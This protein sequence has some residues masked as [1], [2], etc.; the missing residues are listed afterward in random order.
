MENK[1]EE[2]VE[3]RRFKESD[4]NGV[5]E[6]IMKSLENNFLT[7]VYESIKFQIWRDVYTPEYIL[8]MSKRRHLYVAI[9]KGKVVGSAAVSLENSVAYISCV[10]TNSDYQGLGIGRKLMTAV[11]KDE[12]SVKAGK[13]YLHAI[14]TASPFYKKVGFHYET[15]YPEVIVDCGIEVIPMVKEL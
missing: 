6:T 14:M 12:I 15:E 7:R 5:H 13:M 10:Y 8:G 3:I 2:S 11:E 4:V 9:Y 1:N